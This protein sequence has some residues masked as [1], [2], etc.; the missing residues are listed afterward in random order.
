MLSQFSIEANL[1]FLKKNLHIEKCIYI[2]KKQTTFLFLL[3]SR[4]WI[5]RKPWVS[6][7]RK[8]PA[9]DNIYSVKVVM[10][11]E[12][13]LHGW[14]PWGFA[15]RSLSASRGVAPPGKDKLKQI[16]PNCWMFPRR[17]LLKHQVLTLKLMNCGWLSWKNLDWTW[18]KLNLFRGHWSKF[19]VI[20]RG[21][22]DGLKHNLQ[23][24]LHYTKF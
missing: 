5:V 15:G 9:A 24:T 8:W 4:C 17:L 6:W 20:F 18:I 7:Q 12:L 23:D 11:S 2:K 1:I 16:Q 21:S 19:S 3:L 10:T 22:Q 14:N 13:F